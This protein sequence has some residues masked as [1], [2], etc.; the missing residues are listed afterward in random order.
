MSWAEEDWTVGLSGKVLQKVKEL[1]VHQERLSRENKQKQL[2]LDNIQ[3]SLEKQ[4]AKYD[5]ARV[6]LQSSHREL[7][8][9]QEEAK[10]AITSKERLSQDLQSKQAQVCSLEGQLDTARSLANK[11]TQEVKRLE[12]ELEKLQNSSRA[13]ETTLF[14]TPCWSTTSW[15]LS[16]SRKEE[17]HGN[18]EE[19][20]T[21]GL[22]VRRL[23]FSDKPSGS[24]P[25]EQ[26]RGTHHRQT[27]DVFSTPSAAFP[28]ER[29]HAK[30][31]ARR[32]S[33]VSPKTPNSDA[34]SQSQLELDLSVK[35][36]HPNDSEADSLVS[37]L[38]CRL[39]DMEEELRMK[40]QRLNAI[41][42]EVEQN[43]KELA[44]KE[45]NIQRLRDELSLAHTCKSKEGERASTAEQKAK[46]LQEELKCQRQNA[47]SS[48]VQ[49]QQRTK[50][51]EK[52]HQRDLQEFQKERV[53]LERQH[54]QEINKLNQE[55]AQA[56][57]QHNALQAQLDKESAQRQALMKEVE[58]LKEKL[59]W[60]E[61][62]VQQSQKKEEQT[63]SKMTEALREAEALTVSLKQ[64]EKK[65]RALEEDGRRLTEERDDALGLLRD[66]QAQKAA[67]A[68][69]QPSL[70]IC[71]P[72]HSL[73][74][75]SGSV[76]NASQPLHQSRKLNPTNST[77]Q[78]REEVDKRA[79]IKV[80]FPTDREPGEGIDSEH[81]SDNL[82]I[83]SEGLKRQE[84]RL[85]TKSEEIL[86]TD[87]IQTFAERT[88]TRNS[89]QAM[90]SADLSAENAALCSELRDVREEL[91]KRLDDLEAQRRAEMEAKT[92]LK[93]LSRKNANQITEK[94]EQYKECQT[95]LEKERSE[96][97]RL[98]KALTALETEMI[99][100]TQEKCVKKNEENN[101]VL[102][103]KEDEMMEL[104][105]ELKKQ[106][107]EV[108]VQLV[109]EREE[110]KQH[111][112][113]MMNKTSTDMEKIEEL[114]VEIEKLKASPYNSLSEE[115]LTAANSPV[116]YLTLRADEFNSDVNTPNKPETPSFCQ[117]TNISQ[118]TSLIDSHFL[119]ATLNELEQESL[120]HEENM[121]RT[122]DNAE[123]A[124]KLSVLTT[125][126][127]VL[128]KQ[129]ALEKEHANQYQIK[130]EVLQNQVTQQTQQLTMAFEM[131][132]QHI[133]GLLVELQDKESN[134][135]QKEEEIQQC[136][137]KI[138]ALKDKMVKEDGLQEDM[139]QD[140]DKEEPTSTCIKSLVTDSCIEGTVQLTPN[141][142]VDDNCQQIK[143]QN[144]T[145]HATQHKQSLVNEVNN[146]NNEGPN[147]ATELLNLQEENN[148]LKLK[149]KS[150]TSGKNTDITS[151][152]LLEEQTP[153][154]LIDLCVHACTE[155]QQSSSNMEE[156][157]KDGKEQPETG[158]HQLD[159]IGYLQQQ[160]VALQTKLQALSEENQQK[161]EELTLWRLAS[162]PVYPLTDSEPV[163]HKQERGPVDLQN[164]APEQSG[165]VSLLRED[166]ILLSSSNKLQGRTLFSRL[167]QNLIFEPKNPFLIL[168]E[169]KKN[170][171]EV[172]KENTS[173]TQHNQRNDSKNVCRGLGLEPSQVLDCC[174]VN[175]S[176]TE[177]KVIESII[178]DA[179]VSTKCVSTQTESLCVSPEP[180]ITH[181][182]AEAEVEP[183][184]VSP[185]GLDEIQQSKG[186]MLSTA[187]PIPAD[188]ARL[189]ERIRQNRT[190]L[191]A[192]FDDTEYEPYGLPEV[193]MKGFAD[194]P[195]G[196][197][198]PYIVR[199]G[200]LG[201]AAVPV[202][203]K[204]M[205]NA[206]E[207][208]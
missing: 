184:S 79:E 160:V 15:E 26:P 42:N 163:E 128:Q 157:R 18:R 43:K 30:P 153:T 195:S 82:S 104:N 72:V 23:Q 85:P 121:V 200:L 36:N 46:Q 122:S 158:S 54:Q 174:A 97:V 199:R 196:P 9:V 138:S 5:E 203:P 87:D 10:A 7:Q 186:V 113:E 68:A 115:S 48:R 80:P 98:K 159:H 181:T 24:L 165:C 208:D 1:Q 51:L 194:I 100:E 45:S 37:E 20:K 65:E 21:Q 139:E 127:Q 114:E 161:T 17:R 13:A 31:I 170:H 132:S 143:M 101:T 63:Q 73:S 99:R 74:Q 106:L 202:P 119:P 47:E 207:T 27:P 83:K 117:S 58:T 70:Q 169:H 53:F 154:V 149:I 177:V 12:A 185:A 108:K 3:S 69:L 52:Q 166:E 86:E 120:N 2:L 62:Q 155:T 173:P 150:M 90:S 40:V 193:V 107:S 145:E 66:L 77:K 91:Q 179:E 93:Q 29:D 197:S 151:A 89:K 201:T 6:E 39:T 57:A 118:G 35:I 136:R 16:G 140:H 56:R 111:E 148:L 206:E 22:H 33:P 14:S 152:S 25:R 133:S 205:A 188:P 84:C 41:Q 71:P 141:E 191:S 50:E 102:Q 187:F 125:Q 105:M 190:Q 146:G 171:S 142:E 67:M 32:P 34:L 192:A 183:L 172:D 95:Q 204:N 19:G 109:L 44:A 198:C 78:K 4:T 168:Q 134:I 60:T 96:V 126:V 182:R 81:I 110:R 129:N 144:L 137:K 61:G 88:H 49:H 38:R 167:Q 28:W 164:T 75:T 176:N 180:Q 76:S 55:L 189:A 124:D 156:H 123:N 103:E 59:K 92:R 131:Q 11:L 178:G 162:G 175:P 8:R 94:E 64:S 135:L 130:L 147:L 112:V 116:T